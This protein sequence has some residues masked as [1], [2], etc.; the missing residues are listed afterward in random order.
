MESNLDFIEIFC[1]VSLPFFFEGHRLSSTNASI[2]LFVQSNF[3]KFARLLSV[4]R[5]EGP[6]HSR[7]PR[8]QHEVVAWSF[9]ALPL[10]FECL[11]V[12]FELKSLKNYSQHFSSW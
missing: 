8:A 12:K 6:I 9:V 5:G 1:R 3:E 10:D 11:S 2:T 4:E 7:L